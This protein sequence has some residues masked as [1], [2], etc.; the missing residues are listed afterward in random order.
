MSN[1]KE[2]KDTVKELQSEVSDRAREV[3]LAGLGALST[4]EEEGSKLFKSLVG[5]GEGF[6]KKGKQKIDELMS[7]VSD[8][9]KKVEK[10]ISESFRKTEDEFE[11]NVSKVVKGLGVPTTDEVS[12]LTDRVE[13]LTKHV[14]ALAGKLDQDSKSAPAKKTAAKK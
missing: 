3:W 14:E 1:N 7:D 9:Y 10:R 13:K 11:Q 12:K 6:E 8:S 5:K 4:V 2:S